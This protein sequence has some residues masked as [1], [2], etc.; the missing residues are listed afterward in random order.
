MYHPALT[1]RRTQ[2]KK[3][4][5][6]EREKRTKTKNEKKENKRKTWQL[7]MRR[8][9]SLYLGTYIVLR[10]QRVINEQSPNACCRVPGPGE[11][12][13]GDDIRGVRVAAA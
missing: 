8:G 1:E 10:K 7:S 11:Q 4:S 9:Y 12:R 5:K 3:E 2:T 6:K 13:R